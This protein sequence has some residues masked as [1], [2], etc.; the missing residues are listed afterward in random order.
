MDIVVHLATE[1]VGVR[2][3]REVVGMPG[4]V[5][6]DTVELETIY[7]QRGD[8]LV[9]GDG[10]PPHPERFAR[11]GIDLAQLLVDRAGAI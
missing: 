6:G 11:A 8:T 5:E 9:R 1:H 4:R 10:Y 7:T 2:R 3:V